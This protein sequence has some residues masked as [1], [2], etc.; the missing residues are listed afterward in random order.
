MSSS[1]SSSTATTTRA[2]CRKFAIVFT[3]V[4]H[5]DQD[6]NGPVKQTESYV[7]NRQGDTDAWFGKYTLTQEGVED[8]APSLIPKVEIVFDMKMNLKKVDE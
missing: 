4:C 1:F 2:I 3:L 6:G 5:V 7:L 8:G